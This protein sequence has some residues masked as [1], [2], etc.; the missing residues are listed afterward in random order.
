MSESTFFNVPSE[1]LEIVQT[2][3]QDLTLKIEVLELFYQNEELKKKYD[4]HFRPLIDT[5]RQ[6]LDEL[7]VVTNGLQETQKNFDKGRQIV[8]KM[9]SEASINLLEQLANTKGENDG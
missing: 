1:L 6:A 7:Y 8:D 9:H 2:L 5:L 4:N 3:R